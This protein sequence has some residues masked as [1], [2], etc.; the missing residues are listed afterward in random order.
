M[1]L[2]TYSCAD[3]ETHVGGAPAARE[4]MHRNVSLATVL[5]PELLLRALLCRQRNVRERLGKLVIYIHTD[6]RPTQILHPPGNQGPST[7]SVHVE[8]K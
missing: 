1:N 7:A 2:L 4:L 3:D 8:L 5:S 6:V